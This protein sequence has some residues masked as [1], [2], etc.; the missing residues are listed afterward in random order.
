MNIEKI[1]IY[2]IKIQMYRLLYFL[3]FNNI[4]EIT[5]LLN[6]KRRQDLLLMN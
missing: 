5:P 2:K 3:K 4:E 6:Y 1:I